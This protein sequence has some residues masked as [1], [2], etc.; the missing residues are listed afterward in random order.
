[1]PNI[2]FASN[3]IAHWPL[4]VASTKAGTYDSARVPYSFE[5]IED[6]IIGSPIFIP[7]PGDDSWLHF[8]T[9]FESIDFQG[10]EI[11]VRAYDVSGNLLFRLIKP[12]QTSVYTLTAT[13]YW[14]GGSSSAG[15]G[16]PLNPGIINQMDF[17]FTATASLIE[18][19]CFTNGA[20][21][22]FMTNASNPGSYGPIA[23]FVVGSPF[24]N[25]G[26]PQYFS[27]FIVADE[28]TRNA[29]INLLRPT[30]SGGETDWVGEATALGDDDPTS[31]MT[32]TLVEQRQTLALSAYTGAT[33]ISAMVVASQSFAGAGGPQNMRH[34][35]R[36]SAV[37]YDGPSDIPLTPTLKYEVTTWLINPATSLPWVSGDLASMELGFISKT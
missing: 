33:N 6:Q 5:V 28:D 11:L 30:A 36:L 24:S 16:F 9:W 8:R 15:L 32:T 2:V 7:V 10:E 20:Q 19:T 1:M 29:R 21:S 12:D 27:E 25:A 14:Q 31:G 37:N 18:L 26:F 3:N 35:I 4:T 13:V 23:Y 17:K 34:T 22:A